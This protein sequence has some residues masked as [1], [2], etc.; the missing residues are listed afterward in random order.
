M[1]YV[2]NKVTIQTQIAISIHVRLVRKFSILVS[3]AF[4]YMITVLAFVWFDQAFL[5]NN[6]IYH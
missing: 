4:W 5:K 6:Y 2:D 1:I 3:L